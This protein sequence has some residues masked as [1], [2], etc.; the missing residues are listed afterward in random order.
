MWM[1]N[2]TF[3]DVT[4]DEP[5][6][7]CF[8]IWSTY[9]EQVFLIRW[10]YVW[11]CFFQLV[12]LRSQRPNRWGDGWREEE[13]GEENVCNHWL[14]RSLPAYLPGRAASWLRLAEPFLLR[15]RCQ[16]LLSTRRS[17]RPYPPG[18][19]GWFFFE[20]HTIQRRRSQ[21]ART[22]TP[23]NTRTQTLPLWAPPKEWAPADLEILKVTTDASSSTGTSLTT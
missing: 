18:S 20:I 10:L 6:V 3:L 22:L 9:Q 2:C 17:P 15:Q 16:R 5:D 4:F 19:S 14:I 13:E 12:M 7:D 1:T 23:K 8:I 21:H 11:N